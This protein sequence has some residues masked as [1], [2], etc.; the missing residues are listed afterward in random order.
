MRAQIARCGLSVG[1]EAL[2]PKYTSVLLDPMHPRWQQQEMC[3]FYRVDT[4]L[5][6][7]QEEHG[8]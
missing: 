5:Q 7:R 6:R 1:L 2:L 4:E 3:P 8:G